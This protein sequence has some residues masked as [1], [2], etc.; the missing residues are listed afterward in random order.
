M[1]A[2]GTQRFRG[3]E[4]EVVTQPRAGLTWR[5]V[6]SLHDARFRDFVTE[7]GGV[8]TQLAGKRLEMSA[9]S[10]AATEILI[11]KGDGWQGSARAN[12]VGSRFLNKRNTSVAP[13]YITWSAGVGYRVRDVEIRLDGW[14]LNDQRPPVAESEMGVAQYY[15]LP[16]RRLELS[17]RWVFGGG[18]D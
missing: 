13:D 17:A 11:G 14:N 18:P 8:P 9:R 1:S 2:G 5:T 3:A 16:A 4:L 15:R 12:W 6:Y 7:L 10:M